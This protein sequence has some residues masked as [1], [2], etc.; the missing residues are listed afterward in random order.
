[1]G[2]D[3]NIDA[4]DLMQTKPVNGFQPTRSRDPCRARDA[5]A[6]GGESDPPRLG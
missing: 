4:V 3:Q 2:A 5:K 6:L 1:M